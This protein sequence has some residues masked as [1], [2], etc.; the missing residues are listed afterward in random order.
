MAPIPA[1][2]GQPLNAGSLLRPDQAVHIRAPNENDVKAWHWQWKLPHQ[3]TAYILVIPKYDSFLFCG[4]LF[5]GVS[6]GEKRASQ[7]RTKHEVGSVVLQMRKWTF[8][9]IKKC[10]SQSAA[11]T[12]PND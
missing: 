12:K 8:L 1:R 3:H 5:Y 4:V 11:G 2:E 9:I 10:R 7:S 6:Y